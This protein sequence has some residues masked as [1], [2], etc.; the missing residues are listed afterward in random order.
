MMSAMHLFVRS[1][2]HS[3]IC[4]HTHVCVYLYVLDAQLNQL[5]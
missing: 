4:I 3:F 5:P 2:I 1:F